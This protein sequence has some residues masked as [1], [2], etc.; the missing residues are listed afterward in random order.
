WTSAVLCTHPRRAEDLMTVTY[1]HDSTDRSGRARGNP[2]RRLV[3]DRSVNTKIL[4]SVGLVALL[5][6]GIGL[7]AVVKLATASSKADKV[8]SEGI[9]PLGLISQV[10]V[11]QARMRADVA[12]QLSA[13]TPALTAEYEQEF[14][15]YHG[16]FDQAL[17]AFEGTGLSD[18]QTQLLEQY[19]QAWAQ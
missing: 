17:S 15:G 3:A 6:V 2:L 8:Y 12:M 5:A 18:S 1:D 14:A 11:N 4:T 16:Q 13:P 10:R 7:L 9:Q 19:K